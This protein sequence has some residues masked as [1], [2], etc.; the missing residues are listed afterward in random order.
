MAVI[1]A[2]RVLDP[3]PIFHVGLVL[4]PVVNRQKLVF[5]IGHYTSSPCQIFNL[6]LPTSRLHGQCAAPFCGLPL[7]SIRS[8]RNLPRLFSCSKVASDSNSVPGQNS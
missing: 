8:S 4:F 2:N 6:L 1:L 7:T 5:L 3:L